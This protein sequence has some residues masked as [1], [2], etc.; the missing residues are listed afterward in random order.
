[1]TWGLG[2]SLALELPAVWGGLIDVPEDRELTGRAAG[3]LAAALSGTTGEDQ[4]ALRSSA[5]YGRRLVRAPRVAHHL[6]RREWRPRG[7]VLITGGTGAL[8]ARVARLLA[9]NGAQHLILTSRQG[10]NATGAGELAATI[11]ALGARVTITACDVSDRDALAALL[12]RADGLTAVVHAAGAPQFSP[13]RETGPDE[14]AAV[15]GAKVAGAA[16]L[17]ELLADRPL[18]A[19]VLFSSVAGVWGSGNQ[20][21]YAAANAYLDALA[22]HRRAR[23]LSA[24]AVAWGPWADGGMAGGDGAEAPLRRRGLPAMPPDTA[25]AALRQALDHDETTVTV[26]DVDWT[27][28]APSFPIARPSPLRA[29]LPA[30]ATR[31]GRPDTHTPGRG[32]PEE[33]TEESA[34]LRE[35]L[36]ALPQPARDR[37][38]LDLVRAG[39]A[40]V[41]GHRDAQAVAPARAFQE[42]GFDSLTAVELR[43]RLTA[44]TGLTLPTT[45]VFDHPNAAALATHLSTRTGDDAPPPGDVTARATGAAPTAAPADEPLAIVAMSCRFPGGVRTPDDLWHLLAS[46]ADAVTGFPT[47]RG[48]DLDALHH[49]DPEHP[50]TTYVTEGGFL[51][52]AGE[53]DAAFFGI[54]P[55]EA[56]AMDPQQRLLLET[57]WETLERA[58]LNPADLRGSTTG[59]FVGSGHQGYGAGLDTLPEGVE[60]HLLTG[61]SSSVMSG[62]IAY[63]LGLEGPAVTI[64]TACSSSLVALHLAAQALRQGECAMAL[65]GGACVM[66]S[67][68]AF[69]EFSRQRG[70]APD[71]RCKPFAAAADGTGWG[72][73]VGML[74]LER[75]S[76]A[77]RDGHPVLAV[78]RGSAVNQDG[79]SNGLTA[80][81]GP[82][83]QRVIRQALANARLTA[84]DVDVVE[85]HRTGT[86]LGDPIEARA[87]LATYGQDRPDERPLWLG[88]LK[89][90][91]GHTQAAAGVAGV[92]KMVL[93]LRNGHLPHTLHVD[94]PTPHADWT[95]G[96]V[97]LLTEP[98]HWPEGQRP[99]R[100]AV[101]AFGVSGTNSHVIIEEA[102]TWTP[103]PARGDAAD[104]GTPQP[105][106]AWPVSGSDAPALRAQAR[107]L[108]APA[109]THPD[110]QSADLAHALARTRTALHHRAV[111]ISRDRAGLL[112]GLDALTAERTGGT[113]S[114][115]VRG[116]ANGGRIA[117]LFSG[118]GSQRAGMGRVL[119]ATHPAFADAFDEACAHFDTH[120]ER[121]LR[122]AVFGDDQ[123]VLDQ[124][125]TTQPALFAIEVAL[126]RLFTS[127]GVQPDLLAGHSIGELAA[128]HAAGVLRLPDAVAIVAARARL[129]PQLP[130]DKGTMIAVEAS[131]ADPAPLLAAHADTVAIAAVNGPASVVISG[132][133]DTVT[134]IA[135]LLAA[136]GRRV[137]RLPVSHAFHSP[138]MEPIL[139]EL[140]ALLRHIPFHAPTVPLVSTV[141]GRPATAADPR[142]PEHWIR[143]ARHTVRFH[144]AVR[145]LAAE[146]VTTLL[147]LGPGA[148]LPAMAEEA[149]DDQTPAVT[150]LATLRPDRPED[151]SVLT[152]LAALHVRGLP[153]DL[154]QAL[155]PT[156][157]HGHESALFVTQLLQAMGDIGMN[158]RLWCVTRGAV[159]TGPTDSLHHPDGALLWGLGRAAALEE[160]Q[161]WGGLID[162][163]APRPDA[164]ANTEAHTVNPRVLGRLAAALANGDTGD[165]QYA[166]RDAGVFVPRLT[167][168][169]ARTTPRP[170]DPDGGWRPHGT[171]LITGGTGALGAHAARWL[172]DQGAEH[173]VLT[174]RRGATAPGTAE[175]RTD[176]EQRGARVTI[177]ACDIADRDDLARL[178]ADLGQKD[179]PTA[180]VHAAGLP[181]FTPLRDTSPAQLAA[182]LAAKA[183]GAAHLDQ[184]LGD[185]PLDAFIMFSSVAGVWGSGNQAAYSAAN[186]Y[187]DALAHHR[188]ARGLRATSLAWGPWADGGMATDHAGA[189]EHLRRR[190][191]NTLAPAL[192]ITA[193]RDALDQDETTEIVADIDWARF[194]P[195]FTLSRPSP[196][197]DGL[198]DVRAALTPS[199]NGDGTGT[200]TPATD[201]EAAQLTEQLARMTQA[202]QHETLLGIVRTEAAAALGHPEAD[203]IDPE[204]AFRDLGFDSLTAVELRNR[205]ATTTGLRLP[206][207]GARH[208]PATAAPA[209][210]RVGD[211]GARPPQPG[212]P[213]RQYDRSLRRQD[214]QL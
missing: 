203:A 72:G 211:T 179:A 214:R 183:T 68:N 52:D 195:A 143:P 44:A 140:R 56:L 36:A 45:L 107:R 50:G 77:L 93:A 14:L 95:S 65:V 141:T 3:R 103:V 206:P 154:G 187:L 66:S 182:V 189:E 79:A 134:P 35:R 156:A 105:V 67:P 96:A 46:G 40:A 21:A 8:G 121:P 166:I 172:A 76:D 158:A 114:G 116:T 159:S 127:W 15:I 33:A 81:N 163:P 213:A 167:R 86:A 144:D 125:L 201:H 57:A 204:R 185:Q 194:A 197:L 80:P 78:V 43:D 137:K 60:G 190:G 90:N 129:M 200:T 174:S 173:L 87:L 171:V 92:I 1:M 64:D 177:A 34:A 186:A 192:A 2:R 123:A 170:V 132:A 11:E 63:A 16:H 94:E 151:E 149:L 148:V 199:T 133:E 24:T 73:G 89:S 98:V 104:P 126:F 20:A 113:P 161:R 100:A 29:D 193:L 4:I 7:T 10:T 155:P 120:L 9:N 47:D 53:F 188:R 5:T 175:L 106:V 108:L 138:L 49:P 164:G 70:L 111:V 205:L 27:R 55:R 83:Q 58:R 30:P 85:A 13:V 207:R 184:L 28:F 69:V 54:S 118:Q 71:G 17:D 150:A 59:V 152:A 130:A 142:A 97:R 209:G 12:D 22:E 110:Q 131:E 37:A 157:P 117:L 146:R 122:D 178:L 84:A 6:G 109:R 39:V 88:S 119:R 74:L 99:R 124:T 139:D 180:V 23:G 212:R 145:A 26:A 112:T 19:F 208:G 198:P 176:L 18:D 169:R 165:D 160:S 51:H 181:Q 162:L 210:D 136:Q 91:I 128:A 75:L 191:L 41:L 135:Q 102:P 196:L 31:S 42:L 147:E 101:P 115:V 82:A 32:H 202:E 48:W 62:R 153:C 61:S 25:L 168:A 38:L